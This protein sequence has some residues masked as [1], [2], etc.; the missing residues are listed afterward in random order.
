MAH[1][2]AISIIPLVQ[3]FNLK[4]WERFNSEKVCSI[5]YARIQGRAALVQHFQN[6]SL[7]HEDKRCRPILF[8]L[9]ENG[10]MAGDQEPFPP[11]TRDASGSNIAALGGP[12]GE[13]SSSGSGAKLS[14]LGGSSNSLRG[15]SSSAH[16]S[17]TNLQAQGGASGVGLASSS[18]AGMLS[19]GTG[20]SA[21]GG[22][23]RKGA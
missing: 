9:E 1:L 7:M 13:G 6:S 23:L 3:R 8:T 19:G 12:R 15:A 5:S 17:S 14:G 18:Q 4:K 21:S 2:Q 11:A 10:D 22:N 16:G 20:G